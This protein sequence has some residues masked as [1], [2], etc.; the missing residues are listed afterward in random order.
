MWKQLFLVQT[1]ENSSLS[2]IFLPYCVESDWL[3][4]FLRNFL[5]I[6]W[7][8]TLTIMKKYRNV[9]EILIQRRQKISRGK[10]HAWNFIC[11]IDEHKD[12]ERKKENREIY[13]YAVSRF[14]E[15]S[16]IYWTMFKIMSYLKIQSWNGM[17][18]KN[19]NTEYIYWNL[20]QCY[21]VIWFVPIISVVSWN[22]A[23]WKGRDN[24]SI[25]S[26]AGCRVTSNLKDIFEFGP[27]WALK[28]CQTYAVARCMRHA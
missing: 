27:Y 17:N 20:L 2:K 4:N 25:F 9:E 18:S 28:C 10:M 15:C 19:Y 11:N 12:W 1:Y 23:Y 14:H 24:L 5:S 16:M 7:R 13:G 26:V 22:Y 3:N 8:M 6:G 21:K